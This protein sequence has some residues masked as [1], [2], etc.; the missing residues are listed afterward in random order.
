MSIEHR[1]I[2]PLRQ[3]MIEDMR[4][5]KL[6][7]KTQS[8]Y[9]RWVKRLATFLK[10]SPATATAED[11]RRFQL[12]LVERGVGRGSVNAAVTA[13][14]F[15]FEVTL[16]RG[17]VMARARD[18]EEDLLVY[19]VPDEAFNRDAFE[20]AHR[21][22]VEAAMAVWQDRLQ[23]GLHTAVDRGGRPDDRSQRRP[24]CPRLTQPLL[25]SAVPL[26]RRHIFDGQRQRSGRSHQNHETTSTG[27]GGIEQ[28]ALEKNIVLRQH[29]HNHGRKFRF[30]EKFLRNA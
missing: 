4:L 12:D 17:E 28:V 25:E 5:R 26:S 20:A 18:F 7:P 16:G 10:R 8:G 23:A 6:S 1:P 19:E 2:S 14:K 21:E 29:R 24:G 13:L 9:I 22:A 30:L 3:R 11:L 27:N 15:F